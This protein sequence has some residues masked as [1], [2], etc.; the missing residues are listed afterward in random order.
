MSAK[1]DLLVTFPV[2]LGNKSYESNF[3]SIFADDLDFYRFPEKETKPASDKLSLAKV[4]LARVQAA[5]ALRK[6]VKAYTKEG[7]K[8]IFHGIS[9]AL[10]S[11]GSWKPQQTAIVLDWTRNLYP[12]IQGNPLKKGLGYSLHRKILKAV[13]KLLCMTDAI[14][15]NLG[16]L[17]GV[18]KEALIRVPAP[19]L[20]EKLNIP[21]RPTPPKP[22]VLF[23]GGD[24]KRKGADVLLQGF[25]KE[26][27]EKCTLTMMTNDRAADVAGVNF[28]PGLTYGSPAHKKAFED[29]DIFILP[30]R[31]DSY[32]VAI[33]Q[34]AAAGLAV[35]TT[36][37][38]LGAKEVIINGTTGYIAETPE[39]CIAKLDTL[40]NTPALIDEFKNKGY[41]YVHQKFGKENI[42]ENYLKVLGIN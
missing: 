18:K 3:M 33:A 25:N 2:D 12:S 39:E 13:P 32:P 35:I 34:A 30:T 6:V 20:V 24:L 42:R 37:F 22:K 11:Y 38:A 17:Y 36:K 8:V 9:P 23:V 16:Q 1:K 29:H 28:L 4:I 15:D 41:E 10:F 31:M 21:P 40:L 19:L 26:L 27:R 7:R 5:F 14:K